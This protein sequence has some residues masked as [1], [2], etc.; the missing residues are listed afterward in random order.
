M[1]RLILS[2][3]FSVCPALVLAS[4]LFDLVNPTEPDRPF[5][6]R[7][8]SNRSS[9]AYY[10]PARIPVSKTGLDFTYLVLS[11]D[12]FISRR[13]RPTGYDIAPSVYQARATAN[14]GVSTVKFRPFPTAD[15][16]GERR[17]LIRVDENYQILIVGLSVPIVKETLALAV[18]SAMT[19]GLLQTQRPFYVDEREQF[20]QNKLY[21]E[22]LGDRLEATTVAVGITY[23]PIPQLSVGIGGTM[24]NRS[25]SIPQIYIPDASN[26]E[27]VE[28]SPQIEVSPVIAPHFGL[29]YRPLGDDEIQV[30]AS[31]HLPSQSTLSGRGDLRFW[32]F[33]YPD[34]Q[35]E[36]RQPFNL[37][38]QDE[39]LRI[40]LG[41]KANVLRA[42]GLL[43]EVYGDGLWARWSHYTDRH[44]GQPTNWSNTLSGSIGTRIALGNNAL[45][46][47]AHYAPTPIPEQD[48]R[49]NYVDNHRLAT[50]LGWSRTWPAGA[51]TIILGVGL[52]VQRYLQ[53]GHLKQPNASHP[54]I[55]E[56]PDSVN[57]QTGA[58]IEESRGLQTN[59]PGFPGFENE[60]WLYS[61]LMTL[62]VEH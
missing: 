5:S 38:F 60:G 24:L 28:T 29:V 61:G 48:G 23:Q 14:G 33:D 50:Q 13:E 37:V 22:F 58:P 25:S 17:S 6:G 4:P 45:G 1:K 19:V 43:M 40:G 10:N 36:L 55:D 18:T 49:T 53:R 8:A 51:A 59:N 46:L 31:L 44:R 20:F 3:L 47:G 9:A 26:Q 2:I 39:P 62:R 56:F 54:V 32:D 11:T 57:V 16:P 34:G 12:L 15:I 21:Y 35:T 42:K 52:Q 41:F 27:N 7:S 30:S